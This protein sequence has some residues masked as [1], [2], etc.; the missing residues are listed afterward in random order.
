MA[1]PVIQSAASLLLILFLLR[2]AQ[3]FLS[4]SNNSIAQGLNGGLTF[5]IH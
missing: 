4:A 5:L 3:H 1:I 2:L